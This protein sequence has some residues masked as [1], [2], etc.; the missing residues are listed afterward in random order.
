MCGR[1]TGKNGSFLFFTVDLAL[2][3][4]VDLTGRSVRAQRGRPGCRASLEAVWEPGEYRYAESG[5]WS[6]F[7]GFGVHWVNRERSLSE[8]N[9]GCGFPPQMVP[10]DV[11]PP[12]LPGPSHL[13][14]LT[15]PP[16]V[17]PPTALLARPLGL[18]RPPRAFGAPG[19]EFFSEGL[20]RL[21]A[22]TEE[23]TA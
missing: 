21:K 10:S 12:S 8:Q 7:W 15:H 5:Y 4:S 19:G 14:L 1:R 6:G 9:G 23:A 18:A 20:R 22:V 3:G 11:S 13:P 2:V 16:I 17:P